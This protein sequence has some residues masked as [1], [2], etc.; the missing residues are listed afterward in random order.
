MD[1]FHSMSPSY[2]SK[3]VLPINKR[4]ELHTRC[5]MGKGGKC[6]GKCKL[7]YLRDLAELLDIEKNVEHVLNHN[8][9]L[10]IEHPATVHIC[11]KTVESYNSD[12]INFRRDYQISRDTLQDHE[13]KTSWELVF[14]KW[15]SG[16]G[17]SADACILS[18]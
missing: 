1:G 5:F 17:M 10:I 16:L 12:R 4:G 11:G 13:G 14:S 15:Q 7:K 8:N 9:W 2:K 18:K 6:K 3:G